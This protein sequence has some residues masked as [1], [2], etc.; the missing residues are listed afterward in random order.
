MKRYINFSVINFAS[1]RPTNFRLGFAPKNR[2]RRILEHRD[3]M[4]AKR[5]W[6]HYRTASVRNY[7]AR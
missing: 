5:G 3:Y 4:R 6:E 2:T 7:L 1:E